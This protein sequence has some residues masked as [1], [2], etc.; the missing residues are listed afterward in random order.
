MAA[1]N[2]KV[3]I[4][5]YTLKI[6]YIYLNSRNPNRIQQKFSKYAFIFVTFCSEQSQGV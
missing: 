3:K 6:H 4:Q 1:K 5:V 2:H